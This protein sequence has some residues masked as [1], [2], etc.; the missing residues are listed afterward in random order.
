[1]SRRTG[2][3][4]F[5]NAASGNHIKIY[6]VSSQQGVYFKLTECYM[7]NI[8]QFKKVVQMPDTEI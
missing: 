7:P 4:V 6:N 8:F 2:P 1:M 5:A 3:E